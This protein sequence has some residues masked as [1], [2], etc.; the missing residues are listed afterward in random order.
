MAR[1]TI[2]M[3]SGNKGGVGKSLFC[4]SFAS[5]LDMRGDHYAI[6]DGDGRNGDVF[7]AFSRKCPARLIDLR[8]LRPES[9][10]CSLD[11]EYENILHELLRASP[12]LIVNTPDGADPILTK[13]F[14]FTLKHTESNNYQFKMIYLM[15]SRPDGLNMLNDLIDRF[16]FLYPVKNLHFGKSSL[17][18]AFDNRF[19]DKFNTII[20]FPKLRGE[21]VRMLFDLKTYP[22]EILNLKRISQK[23]F[24]APALSRKRILLWQEEIYQSVIDI[25]ENVDDSNLI[26]PGS[27]GA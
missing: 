4:L 10:L 5:I 21:E 15:S 26:F 16:N 23:T 24:A 3:I 8:E 17:F 7:Y 12:N 9:A 11:E 18:S 13:W 27:R 20:D 22:Y 1:K 14:D 25:I 19:S 6:L 2:Y